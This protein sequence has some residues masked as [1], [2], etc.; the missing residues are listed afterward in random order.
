MRKFRLGI[1]AIVIFGLALYGAKGVRGADVNEIKQKIDTTNLTLEQLTKEINELRQQLDKTSSEAQT[2]Q[3]TVN[4]LDLNSK[5]LGKDLQLTNTKIESTNLTIEQLSDTITEKEWQII[6]N[7]Q[8]LADTVK[9]VNEAESTSLLEKLIQ[10]PDIGSFSSEIET[11]SQFQTMVKDK[12]Y[13]LRNLK[14]SLEQNKQQTE[15][16]QN[17]LV[18]L[19]SQL[20]DQKTVV[21]INKNEKAKVLNE[22]KSK[23]SNYKKTLA[24]KET[25]RKEFEKQLYQYESQLKIA[26]DPKSYAGAKT[27]VLA[28]PLDAHVITQYFGK[29]VDAKRLYVSGSH[30]GVDFKASIG[31]PVKAALGGVVTDTETSYAKNG[32][33]Y[34]Y[35]V[36]IKHD[37]G[38][39]TLYGHLSLV[40]AVPGQMIAEG[41]TIG[42]S[43][44]TGY[45]TGPHLHFGV[46]VTAGVRIV[47][48]AATLSQTSTCRGIRTIAA[49]PDA[50]LDPMLYL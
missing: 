13:S 3:G 49:P 10:Y 30:G 28:W 36:L 12:L 41:E 16:E 38:L 5:K 37:N 43:G 27:G 17:Q 20:A 29:T 15:K 34:G 9:R 26:I 6:K 19:K 35:W 40:K 18:Q 31:T 2:L 33:Q 24:D 25:Q 4:S 32:C 48:D 7:R 1:I 22:T 45:S 39:S 14:T 47:T 44:S 50:Y 46:Y 11:M 23:E 21:E 8:A 42:Y